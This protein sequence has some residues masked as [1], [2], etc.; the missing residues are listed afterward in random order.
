MV[1]PNENIVYKVVAKH[2]TYAV[3]D[4]QADAFV[5]LEGNI[6]S[7]YAFEELGLITPT[8][9]MLPLTIPT[10]AETTECGRHCRRLVYTAPLSN[11]GK[12]WIHYDDNIS[13]NEKTINKTNSSL[14]FFL[15]ELR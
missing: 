10:S 14:L 5:V 6:L 4:D 11:G 12:G 7:E 2:E 3:W 8:S 9:Y 15:S 13:C 1:S